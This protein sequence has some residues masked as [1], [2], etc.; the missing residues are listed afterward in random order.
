MENPDILNIPAFKRRRS[1]SAKARSL[2]NSYLI[3]TRSKTSKTTKTHRPRTRKKIT[4]E[5]TLVDIPVYE[6]TPSAE[7]F[8]DIRNNRR[9]SDIREMKLCGT[10]D[11][12]F[13]RIDVAVVKLT[14]P[15]RVDDTII[16]ETIEGLFEQQ[17]ESMQID[18]QDVKLARS[19]SDIGLKVK[20]KPKVGGNVYKVIES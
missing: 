14:A 1:I 10:C 18:R 7:L 19:G 17:V 15:L 16:F 20:L 2:S 3:G 11:G 6:P 4:V 5:E 8:P 9:H 12:Y 13:D